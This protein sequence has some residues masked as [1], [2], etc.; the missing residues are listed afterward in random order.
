MSSALSL[1]ARIL[2]CRAAGKGKERH[3]QPGARSTQ[4]DVSHRPQR[5]STEGA[6]H[7]RLSSSRASI[8]LA[9]TEIHAGQRGGRTSCIFT[10]V[11]LESLTSAVV[12][13]YRVD[14]R[15]GIQ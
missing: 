6:P 3:H 14:A 15:N 10:P 1:V 9:H 13:C 8:S 4:A 7:W 2:L 11:N 12:L 5:D